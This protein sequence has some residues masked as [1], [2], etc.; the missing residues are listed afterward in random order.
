MYK[1]LTLNQISVKGLE[2]LP[3]EQYEIASEFSSPDAILLRSHKLQNAD[4]PESVKAIAR[5]GAGPTMFLL[6]NVR[7]AAFPSLTARVP[8]QTR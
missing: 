7:S 1:I 5:A 3:R 8:T 4:I 6:P 2:R